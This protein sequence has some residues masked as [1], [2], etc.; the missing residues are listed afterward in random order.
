MR[1]RGSSR[2]GQV[3]KTGARRPLTRREKARSRKVMFERLESR[4]P[5]AVVTHTGSID[6]VLEVDTYSITLAAGESLDARH[7]EMGGGTGPGFYP[8]LEILDPQNQVLAAAFDSHAIAVTAITAG[9]YQVRLT[10]NNVFGDAVQPYS[11]RLE[12]NAFTGTAETEPNDSLATGTALAG[13]ASFRGS[14]ANAADV[15]HFSFSAS[16]GDVLAIKWAGRPAVNPA[17]RLY[18]STGTLLA[19]DRSGIGLTAAISTAGSYRLAIASDNTAG[20]ITGAY[21]GQLL[22]GS[23]AVLDAETG[24]DF[25][26]PT[27]IDLGPHVIPSALL[28]PDASFNTRGLTGSYVNRNLRGAVQSDWRQTQTISG[29]RVDP[30]VHFSTDDWGNRSAMGITGGTTTDWNDFS[31]QWDGFV[32]IVTPGTR[33]YTASDDGSRL[34]IDLNG[35]GV[36]DT[37]GAELVNNNWGVGQPTTLSPAST[38]LAP[39]DYRIRMQ[40]EEGVGG[41]RAF[42]M[43]SDADRAADAVLVGQ[44]RS[45]IGLLSSVGDVDVYTV[46]LVAT[47]MYI[48]ELESTSGVLSR[49]GRRLTLYNEL[50]QPLDYSNSGRVDSWG[51]NAR[52]AASGKHYLVV[53]ALDSNGLGGYELTARIDGEFPRYRDIPLFYQDY[54]G[55]DKATLIPEFMALFEASYDVYQVDLTTV[56]PATGVENV[57]WTFTDD[58]GCGGSQGGGYGVRRASGSGSGNCNAD[59]TR[60]ADVWYGLFLH[61]NGHGVGLYHARHPLNT[62]SYG[63]NY[64]LFPIGSHNWLGPPSD[65]RVSGERLFNARSYMD[66][67]L[68]AGRIVVEEEANDSLAS[69]FGLQSYL[70]QMTSDADAR[71]DQVV[72]AASIANPGDVDYYSVTVA[73]NDTFSIDIDS[74]EFQYPLDSLVEILASDGTVL[75]T[76]EGGP[77]R[78]S[79]LMSVDPNLVHTFATAGVYYIRVSSEMGTFGDYRLKWTPQRA[80][81]QDG[82]RVIAQWPDGGTTVNGTRQLVFWLNDQLDPTTFT[83]SNIVVTGQTGGV[84]SGVASFDPITSTLTW[85]ADSVL[86]PDTYTVTLRGNTTGIKDLRGNRLDGETDGSFAW[87]ELSGNGA[88]GGDFTSSFIINAVDATPA[89]VNWSTTW[90]HPHDRT[91]FE[92]FFSD[93]LDVR[94]VYSQPFTLRGAGT[95]KSFGTSDDTFSPVDVLYNR[96][97]ATVNPLLRVYTRG[98]LAPDSYRLEASLLDAAGHAVNLSQVFAVAGTVPAS[99]LFT[100]TAQTTPGLVGSYVNTSLRGYGTQDDWRVSQTIAGT[101]TD[102]QIDFRSNGFGTRST[103]GITGGADADWDNFSVQWDGVI[104]IPENG[105][106]LFTRSDDGSRLW[107]DVNGDGAFGSSG[108]EFVNNNWG[109][110]QG[111]TTGPA[112]VPLNAGTYRVRVQYEEGGGG[113]NVQLLWDYGGG[114]TVMEGMVSSPKVVGSNIVPNTSL[115]TIPENVEITFSERIATASLT[116]DSFRIRYST[117]STF[118]DG[119]DVFIAEADDAIAWDAAYRKAIFTPASPLANGYYLIELEGDAGGIASP[120]GR[121]LDGEFRD[122]NIAGGTPEYGW[123]IAPSGDGVPGG[124]YRALFTV[125]TVP[126]LILTLSTDT[127][128]ENA[129][130]SA[131][132][133]TLQRRF[134][135]LSV[136]L[137]V[138]LTSDD[139]SE[140]SVA[141]TVTFAPNQTSLTFPIDAIDD[142][143]LDGVQTITIRASAAGFITGVDSLLVTDFETLSLSINPSSIR[144]SGGTA[145]AT[146]TRNNTDL[147]QPLTVTLASSDLSEATVPVTVVIPANAA[148]QT[149]TVTAVDD[150]LLDGSQFLTISASAPGY[151][152]AATSNLQVTDVELISIS[153]AVASISELGGTTTA[154]VT[155]GNSDRSLPLT[156]NLATND[157]TEAA[158]PASVTIPANQ[159]SVTFTVTAVDDT[160]LDGSQTVSITASATGYDAPASASLVVT[161]HETVVVTLAQSSISELGGSTTATVRRQNTDITQPLTVT[162]SSSDTTEATVPASV[163]IAAN[164]ATATFTVNAVDDSL[165]DGTRSL[166]IN[167]AAD[168][169]VSVPA[170]LQVTDQETLSVAILADSISEAG[171]TTTVR[172]T[173]G[174]TDVSQALTVTLNASPSGQV[175][176]PA[177]VIIP[178]NATESTFNLTAIDDTLLDGDQ[179]VTVSASAAGYVSASDSVLVTDFESLSFSLAASAISESQGTTTATVTRGNTDR[180]QPLTVGIDVDIPGAV[181]VPATVVIPANQMFANFSINA[182][183]DTLL[184]GTQTVRITVSATGYAESVSRTL[185]VL[186]FE[187]VTL[188]MESST[189]SESI[190]VTQ[191]FVTRSNSD[192]ASPLTIQLLSSNPSVATVPASVTIP[193]GLATASYSISIIDNTTL[194]ATRSV[195]ISATAAGYAAITPTGLNVMDHE[196][197]TLT[198][199][200]STISERAGSTT[201]TVTRQNTDIAQALSVT[202]AGGNPAQATLPNAVTIPAGQTSVTFSIAAVDDSLLDGDQVLP[203]SASATGYA[204]P[205]VAPLTITDFETMAMTISVSPISEN[206]GESI[207]TIIRQNSDVAQPLVVTIS[208]DSPSQLTLPATVEIPAGRSAATF[209]IVAVDDLLLNGTRSVRVFGAATG[210]AASASGLVEL[211]DYETLTLI[212]TP[213]SISEAGGIATGTVTR[214]NTDVASPLTVSLS[215]DLVSAATVPLTVTIPVGEMSADFEIHAID[216]AVMDGSRS[217]IV[218]ASASGYEG[219]EQASLTV[220][221]SEITLSHHNPRNSLDVND[222]G[223]VHPIDALLVIN[224]LNNEG[225]GDLPP[226]SGILAPPYL[227]TSGDERI[228]PLDGLLVIT[229]L[230]E[231]PAAE[232]EVIATSVAAPDSSSAASSDESS[233]LGTASEALSLLDAALLQILSERANQVVRQSPVGL[234]TSLEV[235]FSHGGLQLFAGESSE[236]IVGQRLVQEPIRERIV[237]GTPARL[238]VEPLLGVDDA[239]RRRPQFDLI[240]APA[241]RQLQHASRLNRQLGKNAAEE[242]AEDQGIE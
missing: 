171:G 202:I 117:D 188:S 157:A 114:R 69:A 11:L 102:R 146:V 147:S 8:T 206:G 145:T 42:L 197:L 176:V 31:V 190:G 222:D 64:D 104:V 93:E 153:L 59:W 234:P 142:T 18:S 24:N 138:T 119:N 87:P 201:A 58:P 30:L 68:E 120:G 62:M 220:L 227:D 100:S 79:G 33:L 228:A 46:D 174:N 200:A 71:N 103:V 116:T 4:L 213:S 217:V 72:V 183:D 225:P 9:D 232:G 143:L 179:T 175:S 36:F 130:A 199:G 219:T 155:R 122:A 181:T 81:D 235:V 132:T 208:S 39:G 152:A 6:H 52:T 29:T 57:S 34:W 238:H 162:L 151:A 91:V 5:L 195:I 161:D 2:F 125:M 65:A 193:S 92:L 149:F 164:E 169:Y 184:D 112:S 99:A 101:R 78:D 44:T 60:L 110:V 15:D 54:T 109:G 159:A 172:V 198:L 170:N 96:I 186:D 185:D 98:V 86:P 180:S 187:T 74:A 218:S 19:T 38:P 113:N 131:A 67:I 215:S 124:D 139:A 207:A 166:T 107:I 13:Q 40:Y 182:I 77:D 128:A 226:R 210:Y 94:S 23:Q 56:K 173:R 53:E 43:W 111:A 126:E 27:P 240:D 237:L 49:Q 115:D 21:F 50:G 231:L 70:T 136:S 47:G 12:T 163:T 242:F 192:L 211:T 97:G 105:V 75:A 85:L 1:R 25:E 194:N 204:A 32:R 88:V 140:A 177:T 63:G 135:D 221:D 66:W 154:T 48:F 10:A 3:S 26:S 17:V 55:Y 73:A 148:S 22:V 216:N 123:N 150:S 141:G 158:V 212:V 61:E 191:G 95:D 189:V 14:L 76:N 133:A 121:T 37:S 51:W 108:S 214:N 203:L 239:S 137:V 20:A 84:R 35:D 82:P 106:R 7:T 205:A 127:I 167:A 83:A 209:S 144:E 89:V 156:V 129:G 45:G 80:F 41:N 224:Y 233:T 118:Y 178:A 168:G 28:S 223:D 196:T 90:R 230:N 134:S 241:G 160:L 236:R 229:Y 16:A 165:L